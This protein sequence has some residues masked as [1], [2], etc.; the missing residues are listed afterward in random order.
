MWGIGGRVN[1]PTGGYTVCRPPPIPPPKNRRKQRRVTRRHAR[2]HAPPMRKLRRSRAQG[3]YIAWMVK[4]GVSMLVF[5]LA[6]VLVRMPS[7]C[8]WVNKGTRVELWGLGPHHE[9]TPQSFLLLYPALNPP[10]QSPRNHAPQNDTIPVG[11][12]QDQA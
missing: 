7:S 6:L 9:A 5:V 11:S 4:P 2:T 8:V 1:R 3:R 10:P 12:R